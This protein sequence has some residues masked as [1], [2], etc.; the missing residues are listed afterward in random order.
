MS[1]QQDNQ[2][3]KNLT[4]AV[5]KNTYI[6]KFVNSNSCVPEPALSRIT[7]ALFWQQ[8]LKSRMAQT[9]SL[10]STAPRNFPLL[11]FIAT[12]DANGI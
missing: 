10:H 9:L 1:I 5:I 6:Y 3:Y 12:P 7:D 11:S 2:N 8:P 4:N